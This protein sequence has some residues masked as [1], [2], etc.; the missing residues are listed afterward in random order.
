MRRERKLFWEERI[1]DD[2]YVRSFTVAT[3]FVLISEES[4]VRAV[5]VGTLFQSRRLVSVFGESTVNNTWMM[6]SVTRGVG[7]PQSCFHQSFSFFQILFT[8][9]WSEW[10]EAR[11]EGETACQTILIMQHKASLLVLGCSFRVTRHV[12]EPAMRMMFPAHSHKGIFSLPRPPIPN[13]SLAN[14]LLFDPARLRS[15]PTSKKNPPP[16]KY[17]NDQS[18][19][20]LRAISSAPSLVLFPPI[21]PL[22]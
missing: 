4:F 12:Y 15:R 2:E 9:G 5:A 19:T 1:G 14:S 17:E 6:G 20:A 3:A 8:V 22:A 13:A 7:E 21:K 11:C 10:L 18:S 16:Q